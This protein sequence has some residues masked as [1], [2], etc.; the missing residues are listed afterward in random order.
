VDETIMR[1]RVATARVARLA[2]VTPE[3]QPHIVPCCFVLAGNTVYS[4]VDTKPKTTMALRRLANVSANPAAALL[5]DEY[6]DDDWSSLWWIR[7]DGNARI[8]AGAVERTSALTLLAAKY[9]QYRRTPPPG[10]VLAVAITTW[11]AWP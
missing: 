8:A 2:T 11:R 6:N 5:L 3:G 9:R 1:E 4:A 10:P 7:L